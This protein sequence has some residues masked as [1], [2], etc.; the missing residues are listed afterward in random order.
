MHPGEAFKKTQKT[1]GFPKDAFELESYLESYLSLALLQASHLLPKEATILRVTPHDIEPILP[2]FSSP[3]SYLIHAIHLYELLQ[4]QAIP[5]P[6]A[7]AWEYIKKT[8]SA[9]QCIKK[10]LDSEEDPLTSSF[11]WFH[12][13]DTEEICSRLSNDV[14]SQLLSLFINQDS[15]QN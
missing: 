8:D 2:P 4:N 11:W 15:Q 9:S 5:L 3:E 6:S 10:L 12:N 7:Q 14:L 13:R 1:L